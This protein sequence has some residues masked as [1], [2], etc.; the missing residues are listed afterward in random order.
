MD[1]RE[2][3]D[4]TRRFAVRTVRF[5]RTLPSTWEARRIGGQLIDASTSVYANYRATCR[6]R[7][8]AEFISKLGTVAEEADECLAWY[9]LI[10]AL[11]MAQGRELTWLRGDAG[12][13]LAIFAAS[14]KT[15]KEN[16]PRSTYVGLDAKLNRHLPDRQSKITGGTP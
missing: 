5:C 8:R 7:S 2:L 4:R 3:Q 6:A 14:Q 16:R 12:E 15:A 10:D 9:E 1:K 13:L 11:E